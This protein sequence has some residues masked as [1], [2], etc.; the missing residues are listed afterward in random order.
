MT[1]DHPL[2]NRDSAQAFLVDG[3]VLIVATGTVEAG[4]QVGIARLE[5]STD[6]LELRLPSASAAFRLE[7]RTKAAGASTG[8]G[9]Y[10]VA[11]PFLLTGDPERVRLATV[12]TL[13]HASGVDELTLEPLPEELAEFASTLPRDAGVDAT[14]YSSDLDLGQAI[15]N[16]VQDLGPGFLGPGLDA[17]IPVTV[18]EI[19]ALFGGKGVFHHLYVRVVARRPDRSSPAIP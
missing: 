19:G 8:A 11:E 15:R 2:A 13:H 6:P 12:V 17:A 9:T 10:T 5:P 3:W 16:A 7:L 18:S 14:G 4:G 1:N